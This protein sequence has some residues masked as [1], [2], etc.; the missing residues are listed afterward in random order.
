MIKAMQAQI[1]T[2]Q[3]KI[4]SLESLLSQKKETSDK[5]TGDQ[6]KHANLT[7][8]KCKKKG[9]IAKNCPE[10]TESS[11]KKDGNADKGKDSKKTGPTSPYKI[12]P[13]DNEPKTK[14]IEDV[15]CAWCDRCK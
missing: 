8:R 12:P 14:K 5:T 7:C 10:K 6:D 15:E 9:H 2:S 1:K 3:D 13:T 11:D 4:K